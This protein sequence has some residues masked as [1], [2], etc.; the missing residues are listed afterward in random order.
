[1]ASELGIVRCGNCGRKYI[2]GRC[3]FCPE[4]VTKSVT[5]DNNVTNNV[6]RPGRPKKYGSDAER[7]AAWRRKA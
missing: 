5:P 4:D 2:G 1:M 3:P 7:Q 6:T